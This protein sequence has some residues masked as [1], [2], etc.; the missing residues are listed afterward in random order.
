MKAQMK[1]YYAAMA[2]LAVISLGAITWQY[3]ISRGAV[4]DEQKV[5]DISSLQLAIDE[6]VQ[7][8]GEAPKTLQSLDLEGSIVKR[9]HTYEYSHSE[10]TF[11]ICATFATDT[12]VDEY[13]DSE[14]PY[15][16]KK[17]RQCFTSDLYLY[18]SYYDP[19]FDNI[20]PDSYSQ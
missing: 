14:S 18:D 6:Y 10:D 3:V 20:F 19:D 5:S 17:G 13:S 15:W 1:K 2:V 4:A 16:H 7:T 8:E 9:L 12:T 11:T